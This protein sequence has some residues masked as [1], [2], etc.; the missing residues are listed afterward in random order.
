MNPYGPVVENLI[1]QFQA[2]PGIGRKSAER[3]AH[4]IL[5]TTADDALQLARAIE[6]VK[7]QVRPCSV[8]YNLTDDETCRICS[9]SRRDPQT[10][11]VVELPRDLTAVESA[12][13]FSGVY[14]VLQGRISPLE[15]VGPEQLTIDALMKRVKQ[16]PVTEIVMATNPT[17]EG[18]GTALF[19]SNLLEGLPVKITRLARGIAAGSVLEF[20]NREV[21]AD[22]MKGRQPF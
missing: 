19:L 3:L 6:Q 1:D 22:A 20:S 18:D 13:A 5:Q 16:T 10:V 4:H 15:G 17:L 7:E 9:D 11:C 21:L 8:C 2:L 14:H 12:G